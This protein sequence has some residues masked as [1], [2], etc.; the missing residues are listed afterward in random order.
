[1]RRVNPTNAATKPGNGAFGLAGAALDLASCDTLPSAGERPRGRLPAG[2][3]IGGYQIEG[4]IGVGGTCE[5]YCARARSGARVA[6]RVPRR[7]TLERSPCFGDRLVRAS[8]WMR[9]VDHPNV[10]RVLDHGVTDEPA[11]RPFQIVEL[12]DGEG[13]DALLAGEGPRPWRWVVAVVVQ[14][15]EALDCLHRAGFVHCDVKPANAMIVAGEGGPRVKLLDCDLAWRIGAPKEPG[16]APGTP[17]YIPPEHALGVRPTPRTDVYALGVLAVELLLGRCPFG[18]SD[19]LGLLRSASSWPV[20]GDIAG[21]YAEAGRDVCELPERLRGLLRRMTSPQRQR[22][23]RSMRVCAE[24]LRGLLR[25]RGRP[26]RV[27]VLRERATGAVTRALPAA[28]GVALGLGA[29]EVNAEGARGPAVS[30]IAI[31][32]PTSLVAPLDAPAPRGSSLLTGVGKALAGI[33]LALGLL[34]A[35]QVVDR[36]AEAPATFDSVEVLRP[37]ERAPSLI[38]DGA[39]PQR[40]V[41]QLATPPDEEEAAPREEE[42]AAAPQRPT[43]RRRVPELAAE[44]AP[45]SE[46]RPRKRM[47]HK[48]VPLLDPGQEIVAV[49]APYVCP[50]ARPQ[51]GGACIPADPQPTCIYNGDGSLVSAR[52]IGGQWS[53]AGD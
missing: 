34:G 31:E 41:T 21:L 32:A 17:R 25:E 36:I 8:L 40:G 10:V 11:P 23:P 52:C 5:V 49:A 1:M 39:A 3:W 38:P 9:R 15:A 51:A 37:L 48:R 18:D 30:A 46:P 4:C 28:A 22:R 47:P 29:T 53:V 42:A 33:G 16:V 19:F 26:Q 44:T 43:T 35:P 27:V 45:T 24:E 2:T 6:I 13:L 7:V 12:V 50:S 20:I 14:L